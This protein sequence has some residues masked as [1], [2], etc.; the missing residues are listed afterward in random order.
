MAEIFTM[1]IKPLFSK[2]ISIAWENKD[3]IGLYLKTKLGI[4]K[5]K[6]IRFSISHLF[7]IKIPDTNNYLLVLN[8]RIENQLQPVGGVYKRLGDD[9]LFE[10]WGYIPDT[11]KNGLNVDKESVGDLRFFV[12]G[13]YV[14]DVLEWFSKGKEREINPN[15]EFKE[16]LINTSILDK[17]IFYD[18]SYKHIRRFSKNLTWSEYFNCHEI[19][20]YDI[21]ELLPN[22]KQKNALI[23]LSKNPNDLKNGYAIVSCDDIDSLRLMEGDKQIARIG[24][25]TK[26]IIN[27][28]F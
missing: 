21:Y 8:R 1:I 3:N 26:L 22:L 25:H 23:E 12:K 2:G 7:R 4:Y 27:K 9:S 16:E 10:K 15:R 19:L 6:D 11:K 20:I 24:Q 5:N 13:K 28:N 17:D 18:L 14:L